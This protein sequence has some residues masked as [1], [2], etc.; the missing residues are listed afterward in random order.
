MKFVL[1]YFIINLATLIIPIR[2]IIIVKGYLKNNPD[3]YEKDAKLL[4]MSIGV[5][6]NQIILSLVVGLPLLSL[7]CVEYCLGV[8]T[9]ILE[10]ISGLL[11]LVYQLI[12]NSSKFIYN[13]EFLE[14][15][16]IYQLL[17]K[18]IEKILSKKE[19]K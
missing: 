10:K 6:T 9:I 7:K 17:Y 13:C 5:Y 19:E 15:F 12:P 18:L 14:K 16:K 11:V 8:I 1:I 3:T 4:K 2:K